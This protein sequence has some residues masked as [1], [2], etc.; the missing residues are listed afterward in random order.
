MEEGINRDG[1]KNAPPKR[2]HGFSG[3]MENSSIPDTIPSSLENTCRKAAAGSA[4]QGPTAGAHALPEVGGP[5]PSGSYQSL[6]HEVLP[7]EF[8]PET[9]SVFCVCCFYVLRGTQFFTQ[10]VLI[11][12]HLA[13]AHCPDAVAADRSAAGRIASLA[14]PDQLPRVGGHSRSRSPAHRVI[15]QTGRQARRS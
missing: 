13:V 8:V 3:L 15:M 5:R 4:R 2:G 7:G 11:A 12:G 1:T 6:F 10:P 9:V 14:S